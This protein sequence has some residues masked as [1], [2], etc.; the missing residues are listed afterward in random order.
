VDTAH[1]RAPKQQRSRQSFDRV[2]D[3]AAA[4]L[5]EGGLPSLTIAAVSRRSRTSVGSIYC[6]VRSKSDLVRAVQARVLV[7]MDQEWSAIVNRLRRRSLTLAELVPALVREQALFLKRHAP[8]LN[9]FIERAPHDLVVRSVGRRYYQQAALDFRLLL[10]ERH[11][12]FRHPKPEHAVA[13][14]HTVVYGALARYLG[15]GGGPEVGEGEGDWNQLIE[16]LGLMALAFVA[17]DLTPL[18]K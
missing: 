10:L 18:A 9:A 17:T 5:A 14:C 13:M 8:L 16:D 4:L 11:A 2:L 12:E 7:Q 15:F 1:A 3:A 6:R